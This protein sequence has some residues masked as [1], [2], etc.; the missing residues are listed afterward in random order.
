MFPTGLSKFFET[1]SWKLSVWSSSR[2]GCN[3][4]DRL[5][6][7]TKFTAPICPSHSQLL[8]SHG[9]QN[10]ACLFVKFQ[11]FLQ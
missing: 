9:Q 8:Y 11:G 5:P 2:D 10:S 3:L 4:F 6:L 1:Q 7:I